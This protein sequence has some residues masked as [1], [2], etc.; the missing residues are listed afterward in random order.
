MVN[1]VGVVPRVVAL[2]VLTHVLSFLAYYYQI[3]EK[4]NIVIIE[5]RRL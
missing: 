1:Q 2:C 3:L 5:L 4:E